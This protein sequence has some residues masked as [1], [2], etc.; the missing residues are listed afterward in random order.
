MRAMVK[1]TSRSVLRV[2]GALTVIP[3]TSIIFLF[4]FTSIAQAAPGSVWWGQ[5][6][7]SRPA[8]LV[9]NSLA[10]EVQR[11]AVEATGGEFSL[12][13]SATGESAS[14]PYN[15]SAATMRTRLEKLY[16]VNNI[17]VTGGP[18]DA[19][20][21]TPYSVRFVG[22]LAD[23][24]IPLMLSGGDQ[25]LGAAKKVEVAE[26]VAGSDDGEIIVTAQNLGD[27]DINAEVDP[28]TI[29]DSLPAGLKA[30]FIEGNAGEGTGGG[31]HNRGPVVC[32]LASLTCTYHGGKGGGGKSGETEHELLHAYEQIEIRIGVAF[33]GEPKQGEDNVVHVSGGGG[34]ARTLS[35][36]VHVGDVPSFGV[37]DY[38]MLP[39]EAGG[40][41]DVQAGSHPFQLTNVVVLNQTS[42]GEPVALPKNLHFELP[43]GFIGNPTPFSQCTDEQFSKKISVEGVELPNEC[44]PATALGVASV[45]INEPL[46]GGIDTL[47]VPV[48][49]LSPLAGEPARFGFRVGGV[50]PVFLDVAIGPESNYRAVVNSNDISQIPGF[51]SAKVT[52]WGVPG[53]PVHDAQRGW[54][55]VYG[56][57]SCNPLGELSTPPFFVMPSSCEQPF[58]TTAT[59]DSWAA[60]G[61]ASVEMAPVSYTLP[62]PSLVGCNQLPFEPSISVAPDS[63]S[64]S[65]PTGLTVAVHVPQD[66]S[67]NPNGLAEATIRNTTVTLPE[68]LTIN[69]GGADGL[70]SCTETQ[71][72]Y[73]AG[74]SSPPGLLKFNGSPGSICPDASKIGTVELETPLLANK[75]EGAAYLGAQNANPFGS[76]IAMYI[77]AYD[78]VSGTLAKFAGETVPT[79]AGQLI[80]RFRNTPE[81]PFENLRLKFFGGPRA[82]LSTPPVCG[83]YATH[84]EFVPWSA[85]SGEVPRQ[86]TSA[87]FQITSGPHGDPCTNPRPFEPEFQAGSTNIQ[88]GAYTPFTTTM[89]RPDASQPLGGLSIELPPG[90]V[91]TLSSVKLCPEPQ[92]SQGLCGPE[93]LIGHTVVSAGLGSDPVTVKY[94]G[95]V[96]ITGPYEGA[97]FGLSIAN[98]AAAGPFDLG[99][100]ACDCIVVRAR[101]EIDPL[102]SR[103]LITTDLLPTILQGI[104]LQIQHVNVTVDRPDFTFNPTNC[105]PLKIEGK[106]TSSEGATAGVSTPLQVTNCATLTFKP[107][108]GA[109]ISDVTSRKN[110][111]SLSVKLSYPKAPFGTQADIKSVKVDL[112]KQLPSRLTTLQKAC[113]AA[114]FN[115]DP[116]GCPAD[117]RVGQATARTPILPVPLN[118][119]AY[120]VSNGSAKFPELVI[121]LSGYGVTVQLHGETF[122]GKAGITSSTFRAI[123]DVP[124]ETF[125]LT[126]PQGPFSALG[127]NLPPS[128][129]GSFC[130][131][132]LVMPTMFTAQNGAVIKQSTKITVTGCATHK[133]KKA[134]KGKKSVRRKG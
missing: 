84:A 74:L 113:P 114:T 61:L 82:P 7:G 28:V 85:E 19:T 34:P 119:P 48:F 76:L 33:E 53:D 132:K 50:A 37:E 131:Q 29:E 9:D 75:L 52:L 126:L 56:L 79:G 107:Q 104:P 6:S 30:L 70:E 123:P 39:E 90:L 25:L 31:G 36:E 3:L 60:P 20:G 88:A 4:G 54:T 95:S 71:I 78:P 46:L 2:L 1:L 59:G 105:T 109:K 102:S 86:V 42:G 67:L 58:S 125:E 128:A 129:K 51:L 94:P 122:I 35:R 16:G 97:P 8:S 118:G 11:V 106:I 45:T 103:L 121:V 110:G 96:Y 14:F 112:P 115:T 83:S 68:G 99:E 49:N 87:P 98:P 127:A 43:E 69:P 120:F 66:A 13:D 89:T 134:K 65:T 32:V 38:E 5:S 77:V 41:F 24:P 72:G 21:D 117:S 92:A 12:K 93:S 55:C 44:S 64:A 124:V 63:S 80:S 73:E 40:G 111:S 27:I 10:D 100:G 133:S 18:G 130:G 22:E 57:G 47:V 15:V 91:G 108:F 116:A 62:V 26:T 17:R 81:L 101:I 23:R